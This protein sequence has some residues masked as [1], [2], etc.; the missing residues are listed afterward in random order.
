M[1]M[2]I[3]AISLGA[4]LGALLRWTLALR[5]NEQFLSLPL[6][7]LGANLIGGYLIGLA[8]AFFASYPDLSPEW[9]LFA[10]TGFLG[11]LTTFST[12]SAEVV[13]RLA[14]GSYQWA[15]G[16]IVVHVAGSVV[17]TLAGIGTWAW[18]APARS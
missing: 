4:A 1:F 17:M 2:S 5:F 11:G 8:V 9:R 16:T 12:F 14:E 13:A 15:M 10:I 7:T 3:L 6:G 18:L